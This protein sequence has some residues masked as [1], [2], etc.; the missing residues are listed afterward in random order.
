MSK[1]LFQLS[2]YKGE[3]KPALKKSPYKKSYQELK[4][5]LSMSM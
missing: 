3:P 4:L 2:V 5:A 1:L